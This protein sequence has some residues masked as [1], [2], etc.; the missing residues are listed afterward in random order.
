MGLEPMQPWR[1]AT[2]LNR[3]AELIASDPVL[4]Q[5]LIGQ[6]IRREPTQGIGWF[7]LGLALHQQR[8]I[9]AAIRAYRQAL[10]SDDPP[11]AEA[12][13]NLAQDLLLSGD[14]QAGWSLYETRFRG[15][16]GSAFAIYQ[17]HYGPAWTGF[18]DPRP[19]DQLLVVGEQGLGDTLPFC[20]LI[21]K[22]HERGIATSLFC[23]EPLAPL[24]R[25]G[26]S[27]GEISL[28]LTGQGAGVRWCPLL[29]LPH[30][31]G[32]DGASIPGAD[33]YLRADPARVDQWRQRLQRQ[34][35]KRL[36]ALHWQGNPGFERK[37]YSKGRSM[38]FEAWLGLQ[39][40]D[41]VEFLSIQ[42]GSGSDQLRLDAGLPFVAG[43]AAFDASFDFR[44]TAAALANCDLLLSADSSVVHLAGAMGVP[45]WVAL[46]WVPEWR[47][48]LEGTT[49]PWYTSA[50]LF[51]Q[52]RRGDWAS[53]VQA[54]ALE[55]RQPVAMP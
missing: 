26:S 24:L 35:S 29:S 14:F 45:T 8:R 32:L 9:P 23:P 16:S 36:I 10:A 39:D 54:M 38:P 33:G 5:R 34:P 6:G 1:A 44:D 19:C 50:R 46:S 7:N 12:T 17:H 21:P 42:K 43:Q 20:R 25:E 3:G 41:N 31:L 13:R 18:N 22:L 2:W 15:A 51:R 11:V 52:P 37:L 47:W 4:A 30:R 55:L 28:M 53:V 48:G 27:L 40:L 49:T